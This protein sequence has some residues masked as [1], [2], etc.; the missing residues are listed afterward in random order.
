MATNKG[1]HSLTRALKV[2]GLDNLIKITRCAGQ[3]PSKPC[4]QMLEEII[5]EFDGI[6]ARTLMIGDS[7]LDMEMAANI[8]V[9][10][11]GNRFLSST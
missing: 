7:P 4:P 9:A 11:I 2:T 10:S 5:N 6:A 8:R 1:V 3:V